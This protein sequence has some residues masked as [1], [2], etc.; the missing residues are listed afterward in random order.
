MAAETGAHVGVPGPDSKAAL[1]T[2]SRGVT[3]LDTAILRT[4]AA[5]TGLGWRPA[6]AHAAIEAAAAQGAETTLERLIFESLRRCP[7]PKG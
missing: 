7:G 3:K 1:G 2:E 5:P 6:I 4:Q